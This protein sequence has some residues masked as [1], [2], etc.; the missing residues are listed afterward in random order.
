MERTI[1]IPME[2]L[3]HYVAESLELN[4]RR[5]RE[6]GSEMT[7]KEDALLWCEELEIEPT[8][9]YHIIAKARIKEIY[10]VEI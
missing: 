8:T 10:N 5:A 2:D 4:A 7:L 3:I 9:D 1:T 6:E